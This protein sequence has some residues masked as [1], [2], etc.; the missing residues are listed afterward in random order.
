MCGIKFRRKVGGNR[1][2]NVKDKV[3]PIPV[4]DRI[5]DLNTKAYYLLVALS[6]I[7]R[8]NSES[9]LLKWAVSLVAVAAVLP[10]QDYIESARWLEVMRTLK[11]LA[12]AIA[13]IC[14][15]L[16]IWTVPA[17]IVHAS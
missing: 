12:L 10:V 7:Y 14:V 4:R 9:H 11:V 17:T 1:Q 13:L 8:N 16:W 3:H 15:L 2:A 6:F 5:K